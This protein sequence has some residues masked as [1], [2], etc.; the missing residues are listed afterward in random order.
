MSAHESGESV[1]AR[2]DALRM[3]GAREH[4]APAFDF[5]ESLLRKSEALSE[6]AQA[7]LVA[8]AASRAAQ[9]EADF[10]AARIRAENELSAFV[11]PSESLRAAF[12]SGSFSTVFRAA[13][14]RAASLVPA[15]DSHWIAWRVR[16]ETKA[17]ARGVRP[18][19]NVDG[20]NVAEEV[21]ALATALYEASHAEASATMTA[22]RATA[23]LPDVAGPYNPLA[24]AAGAL[25]ELATLSPAYLAALVTQLAEI[26]AL[27]ALPPVI[28]PETRSASA[29]RRKRSAR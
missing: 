21:H 23:D 4:D 17:R 19:F 28:S 15:I 2:V 3:R 16:L 9:L 18:R 27:Q 1:R 11:D 14:R 6:G 26:G 13:R 22:M 5:I 10:A 8:R 7:L 25:A 20:A 24:L 12:A 29:T